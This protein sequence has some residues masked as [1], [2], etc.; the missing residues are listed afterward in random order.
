[1]GHVEADAIY[2]AVATGLVQQ[3]TA[4]AV[5]H[6][7]SNNTYTLTAWLCALDDILTAP[8][9]GVMKT[10]HSSQSQNSVRRSQCVYLALSLFFAPHSL[11]CTC[12]CV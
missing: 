11:G 8:G 3:T 6:Q 10:L 9:H 5:L 7:V 4:T 12:V 2:V 1:M